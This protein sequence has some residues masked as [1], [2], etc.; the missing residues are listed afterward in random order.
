MHNEAWSAL[1]GA[2]R[3]QRS[4]HPRVALIVDTPWIPPFLGLSTVDYIGIPQVWLQAN[5]QVAR[6]FPEA[7]LVPG[8]WVEP[9]M[10]AEPSGFGCGIEFSPDQPPSIRALCSDITQTEG[11]T[12][13]HPQRDGLMP[14]VLAQYRHVLPR[15]RAEGMDI[16]IVAARGPLAVAAHLLGLTPF[17]IG[18]KTEPALTHRLLRLTT[19]LA[20]DWLAAQAEVLPGTEGVLVLDDVIGFLSKEDYLEFAHP[21]L[22]EIFSVRSTVKI[23]HNDTDSPVCYEFLKDLGINVFNFTHLQSIADTRAR[24]GDSVCLMGNVAPRDVLARG[25]PDAVTAAARRCREENGDHPA[26]L[27]SAGGGVSP[28][29]PAENLDALLEAAR[30]PTA[31]RGNRGCP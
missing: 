28:G 15:V 11:L 27:L 22:K 13:P 18:L 9:G 7:I 16:R 24:V 21:Y 12:S 14:L 1:V 30:T 10:A 23:L 19:Q 5:L 26:F 4:E 29:T 17:L 6:R 25:T 8:F 20:R 31:S 2:T 3:R